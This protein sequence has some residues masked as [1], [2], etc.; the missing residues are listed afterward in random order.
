MHLAMRK[1]VRARC[2]NES[3]RSN[4]AAAAEGVGVKMENGVRDRCPDLSENVP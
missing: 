1:I 2:C 3:P 4:L